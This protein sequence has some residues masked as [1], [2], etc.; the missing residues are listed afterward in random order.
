MAAQGS[1]NTGNPRPRFLSDADHPKHPH[2]CGIARI[3]PVANRRIQ[4]DDPRTSLRTET[5]LRSARDARTYTGT[6]LA[7]LD[8]IRTSLE[9]ADEEPSGDHPQDG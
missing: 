7:S 1:P 6:I 5:I 2:E 3:G 9:T 4:I 8:R